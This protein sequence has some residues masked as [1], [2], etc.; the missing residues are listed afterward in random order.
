MCKQ[1]SNIKN[2][3]GEIQLT[4]TC[5]K[6]RGNKSMSESSNQYIYNN[7]LNFFEE[8]HICKSCER[9]EKIDKILK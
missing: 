7:S 2:P 9:E 5:Y 1:Y 3:C 6:C 8:K 4:F